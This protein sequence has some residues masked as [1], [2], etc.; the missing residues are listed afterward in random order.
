LSDKY[1]V[2]KANDAERYLDEIDLFILD[3]ILKKIADSRI[4]NNKCRINNYLVIN[5]DE[6]YAGEV[7]DIMRKHGHWED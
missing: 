3:K 2:I 1:I 5:Q 7:I 4:L 6:P